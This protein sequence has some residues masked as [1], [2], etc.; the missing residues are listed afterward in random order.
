[1]VM[2]WFSYIPPLYLTVP[3]SSKTYRIKFG[4]VVLDDVHA[5]KLKWKPQIRSTEG[6]ETLGKSAP[7]A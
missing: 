1:M 3:V 6:G 2:I 5:V 4:F 7:L